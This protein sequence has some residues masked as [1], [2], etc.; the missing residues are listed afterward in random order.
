MTQCI[1][2]DRKH[3]TKNAIALERHNDIAQANGYFQIKWEVIQLQADNA[4]YS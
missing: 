4:L 2:T 1:T 3:L